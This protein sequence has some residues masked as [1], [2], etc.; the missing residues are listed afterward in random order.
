L[1]HA[2]WWAGLGDMQQ[3]RLGEHLPGVGCMI[4]AA[5][6]PAQVPEAAQE[7]EEWGSAQGSPRSST[8]FVSAASSRTAGE[9]AR[10]W[11]AGGGL[12]GS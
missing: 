8:S 11:G 5:A 7:S 9:G 6:A 2:R 3:E 4:V 1:G 12:R 10:G